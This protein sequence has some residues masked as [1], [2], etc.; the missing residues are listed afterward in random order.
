MKIKI[1]TCHDVYN[2]G[3]SLQAYALQTYIEE[4]GHN[5]EI[6]D[7]KP[8]YLSDY[9]NLWGVTPR[10]NRPFIKQLYLLVKLPGRLRKRRRKKM[11]DQFT[12]KYL[13]L[14]R[15]YSS[16]EELKNFPPEA[17][18]YVAGS[19]QIWNTS[20]HAGSDPAF[21]LDFV[22]F[23]KTRVSY[24]ASFATPNIKPNLICFVR[25]MLS[26]IDFISIRETASLNILSNMGRTDGIAVCDP[27]FLLDSCFWRG[28]ADNSFIE[29]E[30]FVLVY[31]FEKTILIRDLAKSIAKEK[32]LKIIS[33]SPWEMNYASK[34]FTNISPQVFISLINQANYVISN[35]YHATVFAIIFHRDFCVT[36]RSEQLNVRML[37]L[38]DDLH[39]SS[40]MVDHY[41]QDLFSPIDYKSIDKYLGEFIIKSKVYLQ[42]AIDDKSDVLTE[43]D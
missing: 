34:N 1:I 41:S 39:L 16:Y 29:R 33:V 43:F 31:D 18:V 2:H 4:L 9:F 35:S 23:G 40:R 42:E 10:Y 36:K 20:Y 17:D 6:I 27:V 22:P 3:A 12:R 24:A 5:V 28:F 13:H 32:K 8:Q 11:F 25:E 37:S 19:D 26:K 14:T 21:Y 7:Y 38:L 30:P 15:R